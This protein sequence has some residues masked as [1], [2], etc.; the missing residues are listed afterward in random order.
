MMGIT[1]F[2]DIQTRKSCK[3][4]CDQ[5]EKPLKQICKLHNIRQLG[6]QAKNTGFFRLGCTAF[7][8]FYPPSHGPFRRTGLEGR[9]EEGLRLKP[10]ALT[11]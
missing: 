2:S 4:F 1:L 3:Q 7:I 6:L 9:R 8:G 5:P 11:E 10:A